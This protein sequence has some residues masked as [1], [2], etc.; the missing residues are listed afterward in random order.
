MSS[1]VHFRFLVALL[2]VA[3]CSSTL[4]SS[5]RV[6]TARTS[7]LESLRKSLMVSGCDVNICF[8]IDGSGSINA[9]AFQTQKDFVDVTAEVIKNIPGVSFALV[10]Y[11]T[12][13]TVVTP[14]TSSFTKFSN[15]LEALEQA[16]G[17]TNLGGGI[18]DCIFQ[19]P[20]R[21]SGEANKMV[22]LGDG[23]GNVGPTATTS[24][25]FFRDLG[26]GICA[27]GAGNFDKALLLPLVESPANCFQVDSFSDVLALQDIIADL[28]KQICN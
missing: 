24:A 26:G 21:N 17:S 8:A 3:S 25:E 18:N 15:D 19:L 27:V 20:L 10:Q 11:A 23:F 14:L 13:S 16:G 6:L 22:V 7:T 1:S 12:Q 4:K 5:A 9:A 28:V 2:Y